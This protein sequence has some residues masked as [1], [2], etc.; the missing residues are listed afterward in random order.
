MLKIRKIVSGE[1]QYITT[2]WKSKAA[3]KNK[4]IDLKTLYTW[5]DKSNIAIEILQ[6]YFVALK[7]VFLPTCRILKSL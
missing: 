7:F 1:R 2:P 5:F 6:T 3:L 4:P